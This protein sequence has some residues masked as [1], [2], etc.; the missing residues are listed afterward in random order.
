MRTH[1]KYKTR[2]GNESENSPFPV[3]GPLVSWSVGRLVLAV[4]EAGSCMCQ[5]GDQEMAKRTTETSDSDTNL[6]E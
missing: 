1:H 6:M 3:V 4:S 5:T 2:T